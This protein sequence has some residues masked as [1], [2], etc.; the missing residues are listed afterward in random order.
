MN[1]TQDVMESRTLVLRSSKRRLALYLLVCVAF[2]TFSVLQVTRHQAHVIDWVCAVFFAVGATVFTVQILP[3]ASYLTISSDGF[4]FCSFFRRKPLIRW[5][6][7][8]GFRVVR[9][10]PSG[11]GLVAFERHMAEEGR[12]RRINRFLVG[13]TDCLPDSYGLRPEELAELLNEWR[14]RTTQDA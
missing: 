7:V 11:H 14:L 9:V 12:V 1:K 3:G 13:A 4:Y 2:V 5:E 6:E 10:P 8:A